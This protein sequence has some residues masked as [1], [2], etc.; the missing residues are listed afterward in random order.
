MRQEA[1]MIGMQLWRESGEVGGCLRVEGRRSLDYLNA[2][3]EIRDFPASSNSTTSHHR[4]HPV[5][6]PLIPSHAYRVVK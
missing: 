5:Q 6:P 3:T 2:E 4:A 1:V